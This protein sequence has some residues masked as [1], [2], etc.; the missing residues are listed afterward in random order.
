M[1]LGG[2]G[3]IEVGVPKAASCSSLLGS[4]T[5]LSHP[6]PSLSC[7]EGHGANFRHRDWNAEKVSP[8]TG[9]RKHFKSLTRCCCSNH[10]IVPK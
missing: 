10:T 5:A 3:L 2:V 1:K 4:K 7:L 6:S 9:S 8:S